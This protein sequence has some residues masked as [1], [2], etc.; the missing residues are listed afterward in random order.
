MGGNPDYF[1]VKTFNFALKRSIFF[2]LSVLFSENL[3]ASN[4]W[5]PQRHLYW[6][7]NIEGE[8]SSG[9]EK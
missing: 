6:D 4:L 5:G 2:L 7:I 3:I 8:P 9:D 1:L